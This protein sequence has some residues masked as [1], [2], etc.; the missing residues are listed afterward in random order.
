ML[1]VRRSPVRANRS[2]TCRDAIR[3][4]RAR[5]C[6]RTPQCAALGA[7]RRGGFGRGGWRGR[8]GSATRS[9][10]VVRS[11]GRSPISPASASRRRRA[12]RLAVEPHGLDRACR[13]PRSAHPAAGVRFSADRRHLGLDPLDLRGTT[14]SS[15]TGQRR[16]DASMSRSSRRRTHDDLMRRGNGGDRRLRAG[17]S[18][19]SLVS[20]ALAFSNASFHSPP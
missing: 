13:A 10:S 5:R 16:P 19:P 18:R 14:I 1:D 9:H 8:A 11:H 4:A 2:T 15:A 17:S 6:P 20:A 3:R 12:R 7:I